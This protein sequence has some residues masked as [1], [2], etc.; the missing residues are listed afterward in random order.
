[1]AIFVYLET[2]FINTPAYNFLGF[3]RKYQSNEFILQVKHKYK[4]LLLCKH[5]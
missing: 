3:L 5:Y 1:M 2:L 4:C